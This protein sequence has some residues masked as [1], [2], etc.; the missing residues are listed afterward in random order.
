MGRGMH[1]A[2][3]VIRSVNDD[4]LFNGLRVQRIAN[5]VLQRAARRRCRR[6]D[7]SA[8]HSGDF[9]VRQM[10]NFLQSHRPLLILFDREH[11]RVP[12]IDWWRKIINP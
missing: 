2:A 7:H 11:S 4:L 3:S 9:R 10:A 5:D 6:L 8:G 12:I 1:A